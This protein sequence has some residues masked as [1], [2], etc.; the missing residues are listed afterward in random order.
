[1][2]K[3]TLTEKEIKLLLLCCDDFLPVTLADEIDCEEVI[4]ALK[5]KLTEGEMK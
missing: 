3:I 2:K 4:E 1:M 5:K